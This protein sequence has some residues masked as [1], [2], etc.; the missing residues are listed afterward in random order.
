MDFTLIL[1]T[2]VETTGHKVSY[3]IYDPTYYISMLH[4]KSNGFS[5]SGTKASACSNELNTPKPSV[6]E[7]DFASSVD[8]TGK[9]PEDYGH[10]FAQRM[11]IACH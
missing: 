2:P 9:M 10:F 1:S 4:D 6:A 11:I 8:K 7:V 5:F 3:R